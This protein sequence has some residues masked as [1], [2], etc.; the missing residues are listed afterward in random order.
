MAELEGEVPALLE[1]GENNAELPAKRG[2]ENEASVAQAS[3]LDD[4]NKRVRT[5]EPQ[6]IDESPQTAP[7]SLNTV[8]KAN[9]SAA[10]R[11]VARVSVKGEVQ[12]S[13]EHLPKAGT[14]KKGKGRSVAKGISKGLT[15]APLIETSVDVHG[16]EKDYVKIYPFCPEDKDG[17][18]LDD[19]QPVQLSLKDKASQIQISTDRLTM[20]SEKGYRTARATH[21]VREGFWYFE[22]TVTRLGESGHV[23]S[24]WSLAKA[25]VE[26]P[27]GCDAYGY[28]Y[29]DVEGVKVHK[30]IREEYGESFGEGDV[31]GHY[32]YL[33]PTTSVARDPSQGL[34]T[35]S[36]DPNPG[37]QYKLAQTEDPLRTLESSW[38]AFSKNGRSQGVAYRGLHEGEY[39]PSVSI[40]TLPNPPQL[41]EV[42]CNF[43]PNFAFPPVALE[44]CPAP[45][46]ALSECSLKASEAN[47]PRVATDVIG[48]APPDGLSQKG[49]VPSVLQVG[50]SRGDTARTAE[51]RRKALDK[52]Q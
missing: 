43:G 28:S 46:R 14:K 37:K 52:S 39:L 16:D 1:S 27:V 11:F 50:D 24:G 12:G 15:P 13:Q 2:F 34:V 7:E 20:K 6:Q 45:P 51:E 26:A 25:D 30:G 48:M 47:D 32:I 40:F 3:T 49:V 44:D 17:N 38:V 35:W 29:R 4:S 31:I 9:I 36:G 33:P 19:W 22:T 23:R 41:A 42:R 21:G 5:Q 8:H 10:P 18:D